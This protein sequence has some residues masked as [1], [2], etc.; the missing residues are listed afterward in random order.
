MG[1]AL[2]VVQAISEQL[3]TLNTNVR[4]IHNSIVEFA[5]RLVAT[6]TTPLEVKFYGLSGVSMHIGQIR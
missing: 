4:Y 6:L 3:A 1:L 5:E 2:Q